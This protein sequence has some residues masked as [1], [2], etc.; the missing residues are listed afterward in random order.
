[1][2]SLTDSIKSRIKQIKNAFKNADISLNGQGKDLIFLSGNPNYYKEERFES[3]I[4]YLVY[5]SSHSGIITE[6]YTI[7]NKLH[8]E[9]GPAY[10]ETSQDKLHESA[11]FKNDMLHNEDGPATMGSRINGEIEY[12]FWHKNQFLTKEKFNIIQRKKKLQ[13]INKSRNV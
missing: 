2:F 11:Y 7:N 6:Y 1:M 3:G 8:R 9:N 12:A 13:K 5:K 10:I 4:T